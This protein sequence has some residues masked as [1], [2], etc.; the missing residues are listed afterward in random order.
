MAAFLG[1]FRMHDDRVISRI[2][3]D[4]SGRFNREQ[5]DDILDGLKMRMAGGGCPN[6]KRKEDEDEEK[7]ESQRAMDGFKAASKARW[8]PRAAAR[9]LA[10]TRSSSDQKMTAMDRFKAASA[11]YRRA[12]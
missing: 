1:R 6:A 7:S 12:R 10:A 9:D 5:H 3:N 8:N 2:D 4:E 11:R